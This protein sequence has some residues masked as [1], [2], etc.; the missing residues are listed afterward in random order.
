MADV[1][2]SLGSNLGC[3]EENL[4]KALDLLRCTAGIHLKVVSRWIASRAVGGPAGQPDFLNGAA[5]LETALSPEALLDRLQEIENQLGRVRTERWG[6]RTI[7]L[8]IL[9]YDRLLVER[10]RLRIPHPAMAWRRFVLE[11]AAQVAGGMVHPEIGWS[12]RQLLEHLQTAAPYVAIAGDWPGANALLARQLTDLTGAE[13]LS[14]GNWA[15][16]FSGRNW[17][18]A[19]SGGDFPSLG[20]SGDG[21]AFLTGQDGDQTARSVFWEEISSALG[22][23]IPEGLENSPP[24]TLFPIPASDPTHFAEILLQWLKKLAEQLD[25]AHPRWGSGGWVVSDFWL[26]Q[27]LAWAEGVLQSAYPTQGQELNQMVQERTTPA[28]L[29]VVLEGSSSGGRPSTPTSGGASPG[30]TAD[31]S[32]HSLWRGPLMWIG[33]MAGAEPNCLTQ[34]VQEVQTAMQAMQEPLQPESIR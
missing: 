3:R 29:L 26:P 6:P 4:Q 32:I 7:D 34:A 5:L 25:Q 23:G 24:Q 30:P 13:L 27:W 31:E 11:P 16:V 22:F 12:V 8:D 2:I 1:L 19:F 10:E 21:L 20:S 9:L 15:A 17:S 14:G 33:W 18:A 28:K